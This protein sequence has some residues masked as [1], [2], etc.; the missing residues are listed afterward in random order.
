MWISAGAAIGLALCVWLA[1]CGIPELDNFLTRRRE[2]RNLDVTLK[3]F[4]D[5]HYWDEKL[6]DWRPKKSDE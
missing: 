2:D 1:Y 3:R 5:S 4:M 6:Q